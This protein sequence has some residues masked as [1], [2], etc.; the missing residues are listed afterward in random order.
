MKG[1]RDNA[2]PNGGGPSSIALMVII[3]DKFEKIDGRDD[4]A[5]RGAAHRLRERIM[6]KVQAPW[7]QE[8]D[9][10]EKLK[11][12]DRVVISKLAQQL[13]EEIDACTQGTLD[14]A[15]D[16]LKRLGV[17]LGRHF[18]R[19]P[20]RVTEVTAHQTV[21]AYA[22]APAVIPPFRGNSRSA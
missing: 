21:H 20:S 13:A 11:P 17:L 2:F 22:V 19:T 1:W 15:A 7:N 8:E 18:C 12:E 3:E 14:N 6:N 4:L 16:Y 10:C 5:V 9:L